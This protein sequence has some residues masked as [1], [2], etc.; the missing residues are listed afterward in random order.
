MISGR[1]ALFSMFTLDGIMM[2]Y[3]SGTSMFSVIAFG[4]FSYKISG[5]G[6]SKFLQM[7]QW[8]TLQTL[9]CCVYSCSDMSLCVCVC[10]CVQ[11]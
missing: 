10:V 7:F 8:I 1:N 6:I 11:S 2:S 4:S 9:L 5:T 3:V